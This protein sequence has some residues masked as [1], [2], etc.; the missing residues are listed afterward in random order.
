MNI[1]KLLIDYRAEHN[2]TQFEMA[3]LLQITPVTYIS[4]E[5]GKNISFLTK[6]KIAKLFNLN[7][8]DLEY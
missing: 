7:L 4:A 8:S 2:L 3:D 6:A 5:K 1:Q